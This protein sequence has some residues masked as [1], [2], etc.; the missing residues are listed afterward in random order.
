MAHWG[1]QMLGIAGL[2]VLSSL[3]LFVGMLLAIEVG[4]RLGIR[5]QA[6]EQ[7]TDRA[8]AGLIDGAVFGLM[9]LLI[10]FTF[11]GAASR[12]DHRRDLVISEANAIGT[13][14]LRLN[15]LPADK[16]S[17]LRDL[18][19]QYLDARLDVFQKLPDMAAAEA[20]LLRANQL[21][22]Q[23]WPMAVEACQLSG[24]VPATTLLLSALNEM[25]DMANLRT[26]TSRVMHPPPVI[27]IMLFVLAL[28]SSLLAGYSM[29]NSRDNNRFHV[30]GFAAIIAVTVYVILDI[31][32]PR[33][34]LIR[35]DAVDQVLME[36][37]SS[38]Q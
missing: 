16:Q 32:Y 10:A 38:M 7:K 5:S 4:R 9:G 14:Y 19:R 24:S 27:F 15:L 34:G 20:G 18:F 31:E 26:T 33:A 30:I 23:I 2:A 6:D 25:F 12:L 35:V 36:L 1:N 21:Q 3:G 37:R 8:A 11:S 17:P 22:S 13:A 29:G 28:L